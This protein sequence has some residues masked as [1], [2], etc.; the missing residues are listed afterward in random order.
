MLYCTKVRNRPLK[1][2]KQDLERYPDQQDQHMESPS[3][4][5]ER[6]VIVSSE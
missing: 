3:G 1:S 5:T 4:Q 6:K 2:L